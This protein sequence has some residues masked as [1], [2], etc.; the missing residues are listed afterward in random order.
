[1]LVNR[2]I[3][4]PVRREIAVRPFG[5][6]LVNQEQAEVVWALVGCPNN[7]NRK[8]DLF[9]RREDIDSTGLH[10]RAGAFR[11]PAPPFFYVTFFAEIARPGAKAEGL[12]ET[13]KKNISLKLG[14]YRFYIGI[15]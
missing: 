12:P 1:M 11:V 15:R 4:R 6:G 3:S 9:Y 5:L 10:S 8:A 7:L 2:S 14:N 13:V